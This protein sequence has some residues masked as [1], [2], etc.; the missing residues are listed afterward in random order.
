MQYNIDALYEYALGYLPEQ[1]FY[2]TVPCVVLGIVQILTEDATHPASAEQRAP[3]FRVSSPALFCQSPV[4][5]PSD[6][7]SS[8]SILSAGLLPI[9][10]RRLCRTASSGSS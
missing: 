2:G 5:Q 4:V 3:T 8:T 1:S 7:V 9:R 6:A 10:E